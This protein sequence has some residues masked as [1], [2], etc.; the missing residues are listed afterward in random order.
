[1]NLNTNLDRDLWGH[2]DGSN[3]LAVGANEDTTAV[4]AKK[5]QEALTAI[6]LSLSTNII[7][8]VQ[9]CEKPT[10]A[11]TQLK[12]HFEKSTFT[13]KLHPHKKY[14]RMEMVEGMSAEKYIQEMK[15]IV[16]HLIVKYIDSSMKS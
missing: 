4:F 5:D 14:F 3:K 10:D 2:V 1:M 8:I 9:A 6:I 15:D 16:D 11:W 12:N 7:P 13:A